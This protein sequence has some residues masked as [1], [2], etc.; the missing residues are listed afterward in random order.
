MDSAKLNEF[1]TRYT[2]AWCSQNAASVASFFAEDGSLKINE[3]SPFVGRAAITLAAQGFMTA[4]PDMVVKMDSLSV[5]GSRIT[6]RWTLTGTNTGPGGTGKAVRISG[7]EEWRIDAGLIAESRGHFDEAEYQ[8]QLKMGVTSVRQPSTVVAGD[9]RL[10]GHQMSKFEALIDVMRDARRLLALPENDFAWSSWKDQEA[11][12][13]EIDEHVDILE[14][15]SLPN[16]S[17]LFLPTGPIQE[18]SLSSGWGEEFLRLAERF[19]RELAAR[20]T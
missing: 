4:F 11:A 16:L 12:L 15:G 19:D 20:I 17:A 5:E 18:V 14:R 13:A 3:G 9:A 1:A 2:A 6:Y 10:P 8:L 7:Y